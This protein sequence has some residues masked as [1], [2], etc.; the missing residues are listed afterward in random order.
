[1]NNLINSHLIINKFKNKV[2]LTKSDNKLIKSF[3]YKNPKINRL[4]LINKKINK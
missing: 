3:N 4:D 1:M 2:I